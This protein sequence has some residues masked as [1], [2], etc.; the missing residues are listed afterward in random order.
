MGRARYCA[1]C[2]RCGNFGLLALRRG[3]LLAATAGRLRAAHE[4]PT[5]QKHARAF[6]LLAAVSAGA[7][8][9]FP[10]STCERSCRVVCDAAPDDATDLA[11]SHQRRHLFDSSMLGNWKVVSA[12]GDSFERFSDYISEGVLM[13]GNLAFVL[14]FAL[15]FAYLPKKLMLIVALLGVVGPIVFA[16]VSAAIFGG[17]VSTVS[18]L[19]P[20]LIEGCLGLIALCFTVA[21]TNPGLAIL[22]LWLVRTLKLLPRPS[23]TFL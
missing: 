23:I 1:A 17:T 10:H 21:V 3:S 6:L 15:G 4:L 13:V 2:V 19:G 11:T 22:V 9:S 16:Y 12:V 14:L 8:N 7:S 18:L 5:M 20:W